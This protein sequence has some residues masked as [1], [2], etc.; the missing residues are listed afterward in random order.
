MRRSGAQNPIKY[1]LSKVMAMSAKPHT[2]KSSRRAE[3]Q[4]SGQRSPFNN[5]DPS[6]WKINDHWEIT[7][8]EA[9]Q[10]L[11]QEIAPISPK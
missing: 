5:E 9:T 1:S 7:I 11:V 2:Q 10:G 4:V 3:N 8:N 6:T